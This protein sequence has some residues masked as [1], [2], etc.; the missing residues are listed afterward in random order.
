M[1]DP[2][3]GRSSLPARVLTFFVLGIA[4]S[5]IWVNLPTT[6]FSAWTGIGLE[7]GVESRPSLVIAP[8]D[9]QGSENRHPRGEG[10]TVPAQD[11]TGAPALPRDQP[12]LSLEPSLELNC[13]EEVRKLCGEVEP[14]SGRFRDCLRTYGSLLPPS[15]QGRPVEMMA[16][17]RDGARAVLA[18]CRADVRRFCPQTPMRGGPILRCLRTH[19]E[20]LS[21]A[22]T[23]VLIQERVL[24]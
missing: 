20:D 16:R 10:P 8:D 6:L 24:D 21:S 22:C 1:T 9:R 15:C 12:A 11:I 4:W 18:S 5:L 17:P 7:S 14:G 13:V 19:A 2:L 3:P 23:E